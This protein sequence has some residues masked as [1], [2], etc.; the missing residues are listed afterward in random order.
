MRKDITALD[1]LAVF[2][3]RKKMLLLFVVLF[4]T[5]SL[6]YSLLT[7]PIY[8]AECRVLPSPKNDGAL[9]NVM[10]QI[11][12]LANFVGGAGGGTSGR[13]LVGL[14]QG[15]TIIDAVIDRFELM[16]LYGEEKR[17]RMRQKVASSILNVVEDVKSGIV[18]VAVLDKEPKRAA[19]M[20]NAFVEELS[21]KMRSLAIGEAAQRRVFFEE[22]LEQ[23]M[24]ALSEAEDAMLRYQQES[25]MVA[26]EPQIE[27]L[28]TSIST[29]RAQ[30]AAKEVELSALRTYAKK[31][32]PSL[33]LA[34]SQLFAMKKE[35]QKLEAK[36]TDLSA[37]SG[38]VL[39]SISQAPL[40]GMEYQ[41][42]LREV[43]FAGAMYELMLRQFEA[44]KLDE[45]K[46]SLMLQVVD[47]ATPPDYKFKPKRAM[48]VVFSTLLGLC[49]ALAWIMGEYYLKSLR[50]V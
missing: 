32:N 5:V 30:I 34:Q 24:K 47:P 35:L 7:P 37:G 1:L 19:E 4:G 9:M 23:S 26:V 20:A 38:D 36:R 44:A 17:V 14:L 42:H 29:L 46:E 40:L 8:K 28:L 15:E 2:W 50:N 39:P 33:K 10:S 18:T 13:L 3:S 48:I 43:K 31:E 12:G 27:A 22:Q 11:G 25:G 6:T 45:S 41:R 16:T 21:K 49:L